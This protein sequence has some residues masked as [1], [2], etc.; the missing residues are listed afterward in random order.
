MAQAVTREKLCLN[1]KKEK[2][3]K[4]K[5]LYGRM[6]FPL[7]KPRPPNHGISPFAAACLSQLLEEHSVSDSFPALAFSPRASD[8]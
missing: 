8:K 1:M 2:D 3:K 5:R 6:L 7:K 4:R